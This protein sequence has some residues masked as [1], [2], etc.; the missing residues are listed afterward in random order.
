MSCREVGSG[1]QS[2]ILIKIKLFS[3][4]IAIFHYPD[5]SVD[6]TISILINLNE[7]RAIQ[8][9]AF[10]TILPKHCNN[11][12]KNKYILS[13]MHH[14][15]I[16][17]DLSCIY[18]SRVKYESLQHKLNSLSRHFLETKSAEMRR[19]NSRQLHLMYTISYLWSLHYY[20]NRKCL[21]WKTAA[22]MFTIHG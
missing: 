7:R 14:N 17:R 18:Y 4:M 10:S 20:I 2:R 16:R 19:W 3:R 11:N 15:N 9:I 5:N 8:S 6:G 1:I 12:K 13:E 21:Y 22:Y